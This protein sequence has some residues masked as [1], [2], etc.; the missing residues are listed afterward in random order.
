M[1]K[2]DENVCLSLFVIQSNELLNGICSPAE[3]LAL[4]RS[5]Q[6]QRI[7]RPLVGDPFSSEGQKIQKCTKIYT[8]RARI[9]HLSPLRAHALNPRRIL[10]ARKNLEERETVR[11]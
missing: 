10:Y 4:A 5:R 9:T 6:K 11:A 2:V 1:H 7:L 8:S 3:T